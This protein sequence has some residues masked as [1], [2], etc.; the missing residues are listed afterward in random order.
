MAMMASCCVN[1]G[2]RNGGHGNGVE[3]CGD[4]GPNMIILAIVANAATVTSTA[5]ATTLGTAMM[6]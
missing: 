4:N 2:Y 3:G 5:I 6:M 1:V